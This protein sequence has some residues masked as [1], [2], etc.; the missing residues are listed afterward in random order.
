MADRMDAVAHLHRVRLKII[1]YTEVGSSRGAILDKNGVE[2]AYEAVV[3]EV[4]IIPGQ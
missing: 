3:N 1:D 2:L 4:G